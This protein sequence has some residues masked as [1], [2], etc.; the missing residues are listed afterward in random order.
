M[1]PMASMPQASQDILNGI[2]EQFTLSDEILCGITKQFVDDFNVGLSQ[3]NEP[4]AM[5]YVFLLLLCFFPLNACTSPTFVTGELPDGSE[6]GYA[7][8]T[9]LFLS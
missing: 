6:K 5:M 3:Y 8:D 1:P 2:E 4:M 7:R 9:V